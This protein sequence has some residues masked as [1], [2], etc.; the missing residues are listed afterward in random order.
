MTAE[1]TITERAVQPY[2]GIRGVTTMAQISSVADRLPEIFRWLAARGPV[3]AGAPFLRYH[4][5]NME[6]E[7]E[8]E[9]GVPVAAAVSG[10]DTVAP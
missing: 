6:R 9:A 10:D 4:V 3:P 5:I 1:P 2:A 8:I 7:L